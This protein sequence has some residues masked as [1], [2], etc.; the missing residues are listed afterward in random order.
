[1]R[2]SSSRSEN[3]NSTR[4]TMSCGTHCP[5][6]YCTTFSRMSAISDVA[7]QNPMAI[8]TLVKWPSA[9]TRASHFS[10]VSGRFFRISARRGED[11]FRPIIDLVFLLVRVHDVL[12]E[13]VPDNVAS[14]QFDDADSL[15]AF[16]LL[17]RI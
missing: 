4:L 16:E 13:P 6:R 17:Q 5:G 15:D 10:V 3:L 2:A 14:L 8:H 11:F 7:T 9:R 1:M 12:H